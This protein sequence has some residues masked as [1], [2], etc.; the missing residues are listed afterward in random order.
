MTP[1]GHRKAAERLHAYISA[2]PAGKQ[3]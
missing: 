2:E 1:A 3:D